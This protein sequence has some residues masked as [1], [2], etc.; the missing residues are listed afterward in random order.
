MRNERGRAERARNRLWGR[1]HPEEGRSEGLPRLSAQDHLRTAAEQSCGTALHPGSL[2]PLGIQPFRKSTSKVGRVFI[3]RPAR[4][5]S[6][7]PRR[8][9]RDA[10]DGFRR[11]IRRRQTRASAGHCQAS[12]RADDYQ[13][14]SEGRAAPP[15]RRFSEPSRGKAVVRTSRGSV[16]HRCPT[17]PNETA[18]S[19]QPLAANSQVL[20]V[21]ARPSTA[22][23]APG[24]RC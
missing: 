4:R 9:D 16:P 21:L 14:P 6:R 2:P 13:A 12:P 17:Q 19:K 7:L 18:P 24:T 11:L 20:A 15:L 8:N 22:Q 5:P 3:E 23:V 1:D 10:G